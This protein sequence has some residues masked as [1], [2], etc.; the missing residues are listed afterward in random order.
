[1]YASLK[2]ED[3]VMDIGLERGLELL[4]LKRTRGAAGSEGAAGAGQPVLAELGAH[5]EDSEPVRIL[6]GRYGPYVKHGKTNA[7][8]PKGADPSAVTLEEAVSLLAARAARPAKKGRR[9]AASGSKR[10]P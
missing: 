10:A 6:D 9:K 1:V 7:S 2:P 3:D 4:A 8:L 5:P